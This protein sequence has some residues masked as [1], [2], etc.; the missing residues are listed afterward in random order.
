[1]KNNNKEIPSFLSDSDRL[2][3]MSAEEFRRYGH[4]VVDWIADYLAQPENYPVLSR[5]EPGQVKAALPASAPER[6]ESMEEILADLDRVILPGVTHWNHPGF[7]AYFATSGSGPGILGEM[8]SAAFNVNAMLWRTSPSSTELEEVT[9]NWLRQ[10]MGLPENFSGVIYDMASIST[11]CAIAAAREIA[12][13]GKLRLYASEHAHSSV[14]KGVMTLGMG[15][16]GV[17]KIATDAEYRM[18]ADALAQAIEEDRAAGWQ[19]FCVVATVGTTSMSSIDPVEQIADICEREGL[20]LHI[21]AAYGGAAAIVP[22]M[23]WILA[24][25]ERADSL[26]VNPHKGLFVPVDL[27]VLFCRKMDA[28]KAAFSLVAE[29]LRTSEDNDVKNC[30]GLRPAAW[31][32]F[33]RNQVLV[34]DALLRRGRAGRANTRSDSNGA[35]IRRVGGRERRLRAARAR[36]IQPGLLQSESFGF[37]RSRSSS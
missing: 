13:P 16:D 4:R 19:P 33:S 15:R 5:N 8:F 37:A 25:C 17:R 10:M 32:P 6:G 20:W 23:K 27:S 1:M 34:R 14:D 2:G 12:L 7:F 24:G 9:L 29:Y 21:D 31:P 28:L 3:D 22:E 36:A 30:H 11:L 26:V 35:R 18:N